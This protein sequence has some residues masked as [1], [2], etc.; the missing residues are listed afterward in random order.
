MATP[1]PDKARAWLQAETRCGADAACGTQRLRQRPQLAK[2]RLA[3]A[4]VLDFLKSVCNAKDKQIAADPRWIMVIEA[5]P[6]SAPPWSSSIGTGGRHPSERVVVIVGM[7]S[8]S[9]TWRMIVPLLA[10]Q[11]L[12]WKPKERT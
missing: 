3:E 2:R 1:F 12:L 4:A 11:S 7:R 6:S 10:S 5:A 8:T 9:R